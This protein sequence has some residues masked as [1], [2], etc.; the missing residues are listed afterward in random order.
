MSVSVSVVRGTRKWR[1]LFC[2]F[3]SLSGSR[4]HS[5]DYDYN[6]DDGH[7]EDDAEDSNSNEERAHDSNVKY[8]CGNWNFYSKQCPCCNRYV[9]NNKT[10]SHS[11]QQQQLASN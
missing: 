3:V 8:K 11:Q 6:D 5:R 1:H 2:R 4:C 9:N 7:D 10:H